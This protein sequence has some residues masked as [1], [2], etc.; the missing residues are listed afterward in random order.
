MG[1]EPGNQEGLDLGSVLVLIKKPRFV[2]DNGTNQTKEGCRGQNPVTWKLKPVTGRRK[3]DLSKHTFERKKENISRAWTFSNFTVVKLTKHLLGSK[4]TTNHHALCS[5][6]CSKTWNPHV[7]PPNEYQ[8]YICTQSHP[9]S[10]FDTRHWNVRMSSRGSTYQC[11]VFLGQVLAVDSRSDPFCGADFLGACTWGLLDPCV[12]CYASLL[13]SQPFPNWCWI[14]WYPVMDQFEG[15]QGRKEFGIRPI[16]CRGI[17][18]CVCFEIVKRVQ[19]L[20]H[21]T[22]WNMSV[23]RYCKHIS[24]L[25]LERKHAFMFC[26]AAAG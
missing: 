4:K 25:H 14:L 26:L 10:S 23:P 1:V 12:T 19:A 15:A 6:L 3:V 11:V 18:P 24:R 22:V 21:R 5:G 7:K 20:P 8:R 17:R 9:N 16:G 13:C 2:R